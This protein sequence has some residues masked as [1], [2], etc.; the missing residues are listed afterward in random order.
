MKLNL[1]IIQL[2]IATS[3]LF[4]ASRAL[5]AIDSAPVSFKASPEG[6][7][8]L[9]LAPSSSFPPDA[10]KAGQSNFMCVP[11]DPNTASKFVN[12]GTS[13]KSQSLLDEAGG[14]AAGDAAGEAL[15][16]VVAI[17]VGFL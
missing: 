14:H 16:I 9:V 13:G 7:S 12:G 8:Y 3:C 6:S 11:V 4:T 15:T 2:F 10:F 1:S 17:L 5:P